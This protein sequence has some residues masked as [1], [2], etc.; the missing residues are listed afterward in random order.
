MPHPAITDYDKSD[1]KSVGGYTR[2]KVLDVGD[3]FRHI[4][5]TGIMGESSQ[6]HEPTATHRSRLCGTATSTRETDNA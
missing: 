4:N 2:D 3:L 5:T 1:H 6:Y